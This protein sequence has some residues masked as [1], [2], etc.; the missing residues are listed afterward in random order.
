MSKEVKSVFV[1]E[2]GSYVEITYPEFLERCA[3][4]LSYKSKKFILVET[5]I[6]E[7]SEEN[8][9][10]YYKEKRRVKYVKEREREVGIVSYDALTDSGINGEELIADQEEDVCDLAVSQT[11]VESLRNCLSLLTDEEYHLIRLR[12]YAQLTEA[13]IGRLYGVSQQSIGKRLT[14]IC[15]KKSDENLKN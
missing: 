4:D 1:I 15:N 11:L 9:R 14:L 7:L 2:S 10:A 13:E 6:M 3:S 12:F 8:Y 5:H